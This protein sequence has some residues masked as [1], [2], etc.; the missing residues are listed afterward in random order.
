MASSLSYQ[1]LYGEAPPA[2]KIIPNT[3]LSMDDLH[4]AATPTLPTD[5]NSMDAMTAGLVRSVHDVTDWPAQELAKGA[6]KVGIISPKTAAQVKTNN[7]KSLADYHAKYGNSNAAGI[8]RLGGNLLTAIPAAEAGGAGL[9]RLVGGAAKILPEGAGNALGAATRFFSGEAGHTASIPGL[10]KRG[11]SLGANGALTGAFAN[12]LISGPEGPNAQSAYNG[13]VIGGLAGVAAPAVSRVGGSL[14][15]RTIGAAA[16]TP[17]KATS[18]AVSD[19][20]NALAR[21][22][23]TPQEALQRVAALGPEGRLADLGGNVRRLAEATAATP[24]SG[25]ATAEQTLE[26]RMAGQK[27]RLVGAV[28]KATGATSNYHNLTDV[29]MENRAKAAAPLYEKAF[30]V[31]VS[32]D[33]LNAFVE[34]PI[35]KTA[36]NKGLQIQ[37]LEALA[38]GEKFDPNAYGMKATPN[39]D[40]ELTGVPNM[41]TLDAAKRGLDDLVE[42]YR[43]PTTGK[44]SLDQNGRALVQVKNALVQEM[45]RLNPAY[46]QAR[47]AYA[48]PSASLDAMALG[49]R[50]LNNDPEITAKVLGGLSEGDRQFFQAGLQKALTDKIESTPDGANAVRKIFGNP[51][52][53]KKLEA[54]FTTPGA[55]QEFEQAMNREATFAETRNQVLKGSQTARRL[56]AQS[57][58]GIDATHLLRAARGD[59][60]GGLHGATM[61]VVNALSRPSEA[62]SAALGR[63]LFEANPALETP[64]PSVAAKLKNRLTTAAGRAVVPASALLASPS[65]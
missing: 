4:A 24:G 46:A 29:L 54:G 25:A 32:S 50:A 1:D 55:F 11:A 43:D 19:L 53:R 34:E 51:Q 5:P 30:S 27:D 64:P 14:W 6:A 21:D 18:R 41:R 26:E 38:K 42:Q 35:V 15:G 33:R 9:T 8:A 31:P 45:D 37:R 56:A 2:G 12:S 62:H 58:A 23:M 13:A 20:R 47:A 44:L 63:L 65:R 22:G 61:D 48:G 28:Q 10:I 39:G 16:E 36:L 49:K 3:P 60:W 7:E 57:D 52:I 17:A 59:V 40:L